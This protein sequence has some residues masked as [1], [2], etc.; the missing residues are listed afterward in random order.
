MEHKVTYKPFGDAAI[1]MAWKSE[2]SVSIAD[3]ILE[4]EQKI[5]ALKQ[6]NIAA[7]IIGYS[8]L[9]IV[10]ENRSINYLNEV[11]NLKE[12]YK[13]KYTGQK[14]P[15]FIWEIPVCYDLEFGIDLQEMSK[16]ANLE[17]SEITKLHAQKLYRVYFIGFLPGFLYLGGLHELLFFER[18]SNPRVQV[19]KG[20][21]AIGGKQTGVYPSESAGGWSI[22]GKTPIDFFNINLEDPCFAKAGDFIKFIAV[23]KDAF[24]QIEKEVKD[25]SY[26]ISK[27]RYHA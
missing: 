11:K 10:F 15:A 8:S 9:T 25:A 18:K 12:I 1:L 2:I 3:D 23:D 6:A 19:A 16:T 17:V 14:K 7:V 22:I 27:T 5:K 21:V 4:F 24:L 13:S 20:S 26:K